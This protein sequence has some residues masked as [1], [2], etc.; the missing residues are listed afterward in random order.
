MDGNGRSECK[1]G[2]K[3]AYGLSHTEHDL[4]QSNIIDKLN[5]RRT[6]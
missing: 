5:M 4:R 6:A 1:R 3:M 2:H